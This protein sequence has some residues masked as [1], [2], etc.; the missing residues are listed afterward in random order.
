MQIN[1]SKDI[2]SIKYYINLKDIRDNKNIHM[3]CI[4]INNDDITS[5]YNLPIKRNQMVR[6]VS[7]VIIKKIITNYIEKQK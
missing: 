3:Q 1:Q 4:I 7:K 5:N 2:N 6:N